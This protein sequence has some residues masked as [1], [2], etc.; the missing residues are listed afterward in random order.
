ME[1]NVRPLRSVAG[2]PGGDNVALIC[3]RPSCGNPVVRAA[4]GR[5]GGFCCK[6]CGRAFEREK[7]KASRALADAREV[8]LQYGLTDDPVADAPAA[9]GTSEPSSPTEPPPNHE[10]AHLLKELAH[11][12]QIGLTLLE[13][14]IDPSA[15]A[16]SAV[17]KE[18]R[19]TAY[20]NLLGPGR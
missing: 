17:L 13:E 1:D 14:A 5:R 19:D 6:H 11:Q 2:R 4:T 16:A 10:A 8:A 3:R 20:R 18:A 12:L 9:A 15:R 7:A